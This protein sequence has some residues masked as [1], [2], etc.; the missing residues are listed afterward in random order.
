MGLQR[1]ATGTFRKRGVSNLEK[2]RREREDVEEEEDQ[3][4]ELPMTLQ[5][6]GTRFKQERSLGEVDKSRSD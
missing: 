2:G 6:M 4:L 1:S 5:R 3:Q